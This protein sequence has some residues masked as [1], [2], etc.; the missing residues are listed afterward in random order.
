MDITTYK[1]NWPWG[2]GCRKWVDL[3]ENILDKLCSIGKV[4]LLKHAKSVL[5]F[6][7]WATIFANVRQCCVLNF[8]GLTLLCPLVTMSDNVL[9]NCPIV[10]QWCVQLSNG[11]SILCPTARW[12]VSWVSKS[13]MVWV[14]IVQK[15][16]AGQWFV[17]L[18]K[19][20]LMLS[21]TS[22]WSDSVMSNSP[23][24]SQ[25]CVKLSNGWTVVCP[26]KFYKLI[27]ISAIV[28]WLE[29]KFIAWN[30]LGGCIN[31]VLMLCLL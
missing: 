27:S 1:L 30:C 29:G 6:D 22:Q 8:N 31:I 16:M 15:M 17:Q 10:G 23:I 4:G 2:Q 3:V 20:Q 12:L 14:C 26:D 28:K 7:W 21:Q 25:W 19:G 24:L 13:P 5:M 9:S 11:W 18:F